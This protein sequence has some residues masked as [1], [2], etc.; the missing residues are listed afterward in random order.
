MALLCSAVKSTSNHID[1]RW[2]ALQGGPGW[3]AT[4]PLLGRQMDGYSDIT[5][6]EES[7]MV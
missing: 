4:A 5:Q 6:Q 7:Y 1:Q 3:R 2:K